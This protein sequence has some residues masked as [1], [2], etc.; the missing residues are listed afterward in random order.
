[1]MHSNSARLEEGMFW[2]DRKFLTGMRLYA[3]QIDMPLMTIHPEMDA[4]D[5]T[6][7]L[8]RVPYRDLGF[9][10]MI[11]KKDARPRETKVWLEKQIG[12]SH[13]VYGSGF[14]SAKIAR[15][16]GIPYI[17]VLEY[18]LRTDIT[19]NAMQVQSVARRGIRSLRCIKR[20]IIEDI[21]SMRGARA[22][23]CNGYPV[24]DESRFFNANRL[25]YLD[26]RTSPAMVITEQ[27]LDDRLRQRSNR[28][29]RLLFSG[30]YERVKGADDSVR[31]ALECLKRGLNIELHTYGQGSLRDTMLQLARQ[32]P[33]PNRIHIH[34]AIPFPE[35]VQ[36]AREFD[37]FIC[38]H[39][40]SDPSCTYLESFGAGL[41]IVGY[42]NRMW[43][44]LSVSSDSGYA[45]PIGQPAAVA[46]DVARLITNPDMLANMSRQA[47]AFALDHTFEREFS[48]RVD[49]IRR[50]LAIIG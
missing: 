5:Q 15:Q 20:H 48:L 39:I 21:P 16:L 9:E 25:L 30:R 6:M 33:A 19:M 7:D 17:L 2:V 27:Q 36:R 14:G 38:C 1:M 47:R 13:L 23:H 34:D 24:Y 4:A 40:Q 46:D 10:V 42:A 43:Q 32:S 49:A 41:P 18:D 11:I 31:V 12:R 22:L 37:L 50:E 26:S 8:M 44:R 29:L 28:P 45:S 3:E 35:L